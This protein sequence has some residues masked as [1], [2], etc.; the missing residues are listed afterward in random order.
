[1][2]LLCIPRLA[3]SN[4]G[5]ALLLGLPSMGMPKCQGLSVSSALSAGP[6]SASRMPHSSWWS[7]PSLPLRIEKYARRTLG[8]AFSFE[9]LC[10]DA[11]VGSNLKP[12]PNVTTLRMSSKV[13]GSCGHLH[14]RHTGTLLW[15]FCPRW[16]AQGTAYVGAKVGEDGKHPSGEEIRPPES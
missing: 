15:I 11:L 8:N 3:T 14:R 9:T 10:L 6:A 2:S 1:M 16:E 4:W 12:L 7:Q 5:S 13:G